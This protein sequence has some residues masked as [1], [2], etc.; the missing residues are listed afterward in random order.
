MINDAIQNAINAITSH[1]WAFWDG[2]WAPIFDSWPYW[3]SWGIFSLILLGCMVIGFFL[4][5]KWPRL[6]L[7]LIVAG[8]GAWL[9]GRTTMY[10]EMKRK[11]D[12]ARERE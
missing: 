9:F 6:A 8:A 3:S 2:L 11:L 5:F 1:I 4:N 12:A 10:N 7:G